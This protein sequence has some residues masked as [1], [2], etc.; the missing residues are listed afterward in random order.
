[1][2]VFF[3]KNEPLKTSSELLLIFV[4]SSQLVD[5]QL[6]IVLVRSSVCRSRSDVAI[7]VDASSSV[8]RVNFRRQ[9]EFLQELALSLPVS[10]TIQL[11]LETYSSQE[12]V[13]FYFS[14]F[15]TKRQI[16]NA[17]S[18]PYLLGG[19]TNTAAALKRAGEDLFSRR[20]GDNPEHENVVLLLTDGWSDRPGETWEEAMKLREAGVHMIVVGI[21]NAVR[22]GELS[23]QILLHS[24]MA[25]TARVST[26][27]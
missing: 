4:N 23:G 26:L 13:H 10:S 6:V 27:V 1:M 5:F 11:A 22:D 18:V 14:D 7:V 16:L 12:T 15:E 20:F 25:H 21:G 24:G 17:L 3:F 9:V 19:T 2:S 8:G